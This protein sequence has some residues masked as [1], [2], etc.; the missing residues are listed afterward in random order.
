MMKF[1]HFLV[2]SEFFL[3]IRL[4]L[5]NSDFFSKFRLFIGY[6][7]IFTNSDFRMYLGSK[8]KIQDSPEISDFFNQNFRFD[9][10]MFN[11][12]MYNG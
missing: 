3:G 1:G 8:Q 11:F 12:S 7:T 6:Q 9:Y 2:N 5:Q 10:R 4:F